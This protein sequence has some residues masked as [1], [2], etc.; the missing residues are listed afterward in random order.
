M[1]TD[2]L[3]FF[4]GLLCIV[5]DTFL[6]NSC[7]VFSGQV[8][9]IRSF[10]LSSQSFF[11][12]LFCDYQ[13]FPLELMMHVFLWSKVVQ[14]Y[15]TSPNS[16]FLAIPDQSV[17]NLSK[18]LLAFM[19]SFRV[20]FTMQRLRLLPILLQ[21]FANC[22]SEAQI[23]LNQNFNWTIIAVLGKACMAVGMLALAIRSFNHCSRYELFSKYTITGS[24]PC[25]MLK[26]LLLSLAKQCRCRG[27]NRYL[28]IWSILPELNHLQS[29]LS[30]QQ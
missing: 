23:L 10:A 8:L 1:D 26:S 4:L 16:P 15:L 18:S 28:F 20:S 6:G 30:T 22:T 19:A 11:T 29:L 13:Q 12:V 17:T 9:Q 27:H 5:V 25:S 2:T 14:V 24:L 7:N 21:L 3:S